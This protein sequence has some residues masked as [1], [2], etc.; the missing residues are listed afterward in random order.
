MKLIASFFVLLLVSS[1]SIVSAT[2]IISIEIDS[3][4]LEAGEIAEINGSVESG[5]AGKP[6]GIELKDSEGN[7]ILIRTVTSDS[8]G[9]FTLKFKVPSSASGNI[10]IMSSVEIDGQSFSESV[11]ATVAVPE[12][13]EEEP[14]AE[15]I[16]EP[17]TKSEASQSSAGCGEGTV[18]VNGVCQVAKTSGTPMSIEPIYLII[19]AVAIGGVIA[20]A[21]AVAKRGSGTPKPRRQELDE[22]EEQYLAKEKPKQK[23][24]KKKE[25]S[26]FCDNRHS[27]CARHLH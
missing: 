2:S 18:M 5:L 24:A 6:V 17:T 22:Y 21:I 13:F 1:I 3:N 10:E 4:T 23:P 19:G 27:C 25:T 9:K 8:N 11:S 14:V 12:L 7:V 15:P 20:G 26:A 16:S